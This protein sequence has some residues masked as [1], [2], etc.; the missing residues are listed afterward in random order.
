MKKFEYKQVFS[1]NI[2]QLDRIEL[3]N[4]LGL[5]GWELITIYNDNYTFKREL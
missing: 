4:K 2:S 1:S 5:D 3:L